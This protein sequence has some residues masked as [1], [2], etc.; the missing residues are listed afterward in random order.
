MSHKN[1]EVFGMLAGFKDSNQCP[2]RSSD[3]AE[4]PGGPG[5][6]LY[7]SPR[8]GIRSRAVGTDVARLYRRAMGMTLNRK[9]GRAVVEKEK[10][11]TGMNV[12]EAYEAAENGTILP[13]LE[14]RECCDAG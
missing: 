3:P 14:R 13:D 9:V 12:A 1:P 6:S 8:G 10:V 7:E 4:C 2:R 11:R 5:E